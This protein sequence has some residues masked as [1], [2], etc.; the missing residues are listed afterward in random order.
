MK[1]ALQMY[2]VR[3][4]LSEDRIRDTLGRV[5]DMGYGGA[6]WYGLLGYTPYELAKLTTDAGLA[7]FSLHISMDDLLSPDEDFMKGAV[8]VGVKYLPIGY[9][10][11]NRL[12]GAELFPETCDLIA[13]YA[14][15]A[16]KYGLRIL[17][18]NHDFDLKKVGDTTAID[19][20]Y[21]ALPGDVLGAEP[22]TCWLYSGG[23][24]VTGYLTKYRDRA[25]IIH[26]KDCVKEGGRAGFCPIGMGV[27]DF[28]EILPH[29]TAAD[30]ICVEQDEPSCGLDAFGC[31]QAS[32][33][34]LKKLMKER[35]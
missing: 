18:H 1:T 12:A 4:Y 8:E 30:W 2:S 13:R 25:P 32:I 19:C 31:A 33:D 34:A 10:P 28:G 22:D 21:D 16:A 29:C 23:V 9:L 15:M 5:R 17:Y 20:L 6:E 3:Q 11:E 24:S 7:M 14:D 26:L 35:N 27:L